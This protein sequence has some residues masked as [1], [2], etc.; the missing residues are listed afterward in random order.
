MLRVM[1]VLGVLVL[2]PAAIVF[3]RTRDRSAV[4]SPIGGAGSAVSSRPIGT[5]TLSHGG[6]SPSGQATIPTSGEKRART[7]SLEPKR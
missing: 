6:P 7:D 5:N 3:W 4:D 1:L 2:V